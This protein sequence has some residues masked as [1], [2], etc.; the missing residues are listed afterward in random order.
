[1]IL[2]PWH[3]EVG[4]L[5]DGAVAQESRWLSCRQ[6]A[7]GQVV[8]GDDDEREER[9]AAVIVDMQSRLTTVGQITKPIQTLKFLNNVSLARTALCPKTLRRSMHRTMP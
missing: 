2:P 7:A 5:T 9:R 3:E 8:L 6:A 1:M 4:L